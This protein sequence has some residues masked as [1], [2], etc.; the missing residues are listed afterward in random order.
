MHIFPNLS[1]LD[2]HPL[3]TNGG[4]CTF[5]PSNVFTIYSVMILQSTSTHDRWDLD[6]ISRRDRCET[7]LIIYHGVKIFGEAKRFCKIISEISCLRNQLNVFWKQW[8]FSGHFF[9]HNGFLFC[10]I[11]KNRTFFL[12]KCLKIVNLSE[13]EKRFSS[14][15]PGSQVW[16]PWTQRFCLAFCKV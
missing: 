8:F 12:F 10:F 5:P 4:Q 2:I 14:Q 15:L 7:A 3:H 11:A 1:L 16:K 9:T 6:Y 13:T